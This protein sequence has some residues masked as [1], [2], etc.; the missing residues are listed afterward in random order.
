MIQAV[1]GGRCMV[2]SP[3]SWKSGDESIVL[4]WAV[5]TSSY[6]ILYGTNYTRVWQKYGS[7]QSR[8]FRLGS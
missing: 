1:H 6:G 2:S 7:I 4:T 3:D 8:T 5:G